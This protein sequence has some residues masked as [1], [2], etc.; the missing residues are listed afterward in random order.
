MGTEAVTPVRDAEVAPAPLVRRPGG[1]RLAGLT[2]DELEM[3]ALEH[4]E[5]A[6]AELRAVR[7]G[8]Q[9]AV[10]PARVVRR[11]PWLLAVLFGVGGLLLVRR[12]RRPRLVA[13]GAAPPVAVAPES[14]SRSI[15]R[16]LLSALAAAAG[17][18]LPDLVLAWLSRRRPAR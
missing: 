11:H 2:P 16:G 8:V 12:A 1:S 9:E 10:S 6:F 13:T 4:M 3:L 7:A 15:G 17:R 5:L 18:A 14:F